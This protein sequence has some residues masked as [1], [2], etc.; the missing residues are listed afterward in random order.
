M[1]SFLLTSLSL[2]FL[3]GCSAA[4]LIKKETDSVNIASEI[5]ER[6]CALKARGYSDQDSV[7]K[8]VFSMNREMMR[9]TQVREDTLVT[10]MGRKLKECGIDIKELN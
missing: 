8:A 3:T 7:G 5:A 10:T 1:K 9:K 6:A 2:F 4:T